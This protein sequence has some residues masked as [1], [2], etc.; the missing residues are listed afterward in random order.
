MFD[1]RLSGL[2]ESL[3]RAGLCDFTLQEFEEAIKLGITI[4]VE[5]SKNIVLPGQKIKFKIVNSNGKDIICS[6]RQLPDLQYKSSTE[7]FNQ[8]KGSCVFNGEP[9]EFEIQLQEDIF[10]KDGLEK[11]LLHALFIYVKYIQQSLSC[12]DQDSIFC[13]LLINALYSDKEF[14]A[15]SILN[16]MIL[17][18]EQQRCLLKDVFDRFCIMLCPRHEKGVVHLL[19]ICDIFVRD[20]QKPRAL[21]FAKALQR[22]VKEHFRSIVEEKIDSLVESP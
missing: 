5:I 1:E 17:F 7:S 13:Y 21:L 6:C 9:Y 11:L 10:A 20:R 4:N 2:L 15:L 12:D 14:G 16:A 3:F 18:A 8:I 19:K 22:H